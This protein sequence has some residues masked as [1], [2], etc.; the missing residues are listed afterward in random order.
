MDRLSAA[1]AGGQRHAEYRTT[2]MQTDCPL[3]QGTV[4]NEMDFQDFVDLMFIP[5]KWNPYYAA[6]VKKRRQKLLQL[7]LSARTSMIKRQRPRVAAAPP[8]PV[9]A[10]AQAAPA[11]APPGQVQ[12]ALQ[13]AAGVAANLAAQMAAGVPLP[14]D[15]PQPM[16]GAGFGANQ[17]AAHAQVAQQLANVL[18]QLAELQQAQAE[19]AAPAPAPVHAPAAAADPEMA[20]DGAEFELDAETLAMMEALADEELPTADDKFEMLLKYVHPDVQLKDTIVD[21]VMLNAHNMSGQEKFDYFVA[22]MTKATSSVAL[23]KAMWLGMQRNGLDEPPSAFCARFSKTAAASGKTCLDV[24]NKFMELLLSPWHGDSGLEKFV[25]AMYIEHK[26]TVQD[27]E[28]L[29]LEEMADSAEVFERMVFSQAVA[30]MES[31][32]KRR[33]PGSAPRAREPKT[34]AP[35]TPPGSGS[36]K[37]DKAALLDLPFKE[38]DGK[39]YRAC[40][41]CY[42]NDDATVWHPKRQCP[43]FKGGGGRGGSGRGGQAM[44]GKTGAHGLPP[45][46]CFK[47]GKKGHY[48]SD[49]QLEH[50][51]DAGRT[52]QRQFQ[53]E[54]RKR[55]Q[56]G[57]EGNSSGKH[58]T[59]AEESDAE[60]S[61]SAMMASLA[62]L[63]GDI[64]QLKTAL[65]ASGAAAEPAAAPAG[66]QRAAG[67]NF[68]AHAAMHDAWLPASAVE[69]GF[70]FSDMY[71]SDDSGVGLLTSN[72]IPTAKC[73]PLG[74]FPASLMAADQLRRRG[75]PPK[76]QQ[77]ADAA[78][79]PTAPASARRQAS[80]HN[81][82][83]DEMRALR[84]RLPRGMVNPRDLATE[85]PPAVDSDVGGGVSNAQSLRIREAQ[86][87]SMLRNCLS[88]LKLGHVAAEL[89]ADASP[90]NLDAWHQ[91]KCSA[92]AGDLHDGQDPRSI[93]Y[94]QAVQRAVNVWAAQ[95]Q[96]N[97]RDFLKIDLQGLFREALK[98][99]YGEQLTAQVAPEQPV[100]PPSPGLD[101]PERAMLMAPAPQQ[102][103]QAMRAEDPVALQ[104]HRQLRHKWR[105]S[106]RWSGRRAV[107]M[108]DGSVHNILFN[109][110]PVG[111]I[112]LDAGANEPMINKRLVQAQHLAVNPN[113]RRITGI[114]GVPH[115]MPRTLDALT[116]TVFPEDSDK[117][118]TAM[119]SMIVMEGDSLPDLLLDNEMMAQIGIV[120]DTVNWTATYPTKPYQQDSELVSLPLFRPTD[121]QLSALAQM[122][123]WDPPAEE[124]L[125]PLSSPSVQSPASFQGFCCMAV[126]QGTPKM[127][128]EQS[129]G[130]PEIEHLPNFPHT[131]SQVGGGEDLSFPEATAS[132]AFHSQVK[133]S[134]AQ[135]F[136]EGMPH[137]ELYAELC[138]SVYTAEGP[139]EEAGNAYA[140]VVEQFTQQQLD[141]IPALAHTA[142]DKLFVLDLEAVQGH[143]YG[144]VSTLYLC[145]GFLTSLVVDVTEGMHMKK[146]RILERNSLRRVCGERVLQELHAHY[147]E[148]LPASAIKDAFDWAEAIS[149]D[150][151]NL[152]GP[153]L[154]H[155]FG[156]DCELVVHI[157]AGC[158]GHSAIGPKTGF[159]HAESGSLVVIAD[160]LSD[161]QQILAKCRGIKRWDEA[162]SMFGYI[163]ENVPG[164]YRREQH[165]EMSLMA[166]RFMDRVFG[167]PNM[168]EPALCGDLATR[169]AK[170]WS[171]MFTQEFYEA[172]EPLFHRTPEVSLEQV[173]LEL[174]DGRLQPQIVSRGKQLQGGLNSFGDRAQV[175]PKFVSEPLT[176]NQRMAEDG[177][178]GA[179]ML[180]VVGSNPPRFVPC[181]VSVRVRAHSFW[182]PQIECVSKIVD[183]LGLI[184][185]IGN[186]CAPTSCR[187]MF[188]LAVG[189]S[190][191]VRQQAELMHHVPAET[192]PAR[193]KQVEDSR[194][195]F[196]RALDRVAADNI[197]AVEALDRAY[198][199]ARQ[200]AK[201]DAAKR[202][203]IEPPRVVTLSLRK[204][205]QAKARSDAKLLKAKA[206]QAKEARRK[207]AAALQSAAAASNQRTKEK[208]MGSKSRRQN[209]L[210]AVLLLLMA[211]ALWGPAAYRASRIAGS[212][213]ALAAE[214]GFYVPG[215]M[216]LEGHLPPEWPLESGPLTGSE[217][218]WMDFAAKH[219]AAMDNRYREAAEPGECLY[220]LA[221][222]RAVGTADNVTLVPSTLVS[223]KDGSQHQWQI[224]AGFQRKSEFAAMMD[225][226]PEWY[227]WGLKDL[228]T[229][230]GAEY[231]ITLTDNRPIFSKQYHLAHREAE[232]AENWV[233]ELEEAGL[234]KEIESPYAAPVVVAPKKDEAGQW[235]DLRYAIDYRRL[236]QVTVRDQYPTPVPEE[237]LARMNG[238]ALF[239]SMDA[240]KAFHQV[241]VAED[242]QPML[243]FHSGHRLLTWRRMP[244]GGKNSVACW[245]RIVDDA[246]QGL[247]FAQAFADDVVVWSDGDEVEHMRRVR[248][249]LERLHSK[250]IQISPKKTK[251]GMQRLEFLGHV[252][253]ASGVEP[254]WDKVEAIQ[255][256]PV[257]TSASEVRSFIGM[258]TYYCKFL[259]HYS[260]VKRP[261]TDL[262]KKG[263]PWVWGEAQEEAFKQ[264]KEMLVSAPVLRNP[265][266]TRPFILHTDWSKAGVG[267]CLS[268]I[269]EDGQEYAVAFASRMNSRAEAAFSSYEGEVSAVVY[270]VQR[271]RYYLWG[272]KFTLVTDCKAMEWLTT[273]AKLRSKL[274]RW[275]LILAEYD[276]DIVHRPGKDNT[277]PDL[278]S[279]QPSA[280]S[281]GRPVGIAFHFARRPAL[282]SSA[283]AFMAQQWGA[284]VAAGWIAGQVLEATFSRFDPW[285]DE[286][287]LQF[288]RGELPREVVSALRWAALRRQCS[289]YMAREG[290]IWYRTATGQ[291]LEV[292]PPAQRQAVV[293]RIHEE[294]GHL[295]RDRTHAMAAHRYTWPAMW[296]TVADTIKSCSQCDRVR[297]SFDRQVDV[298]RPLPLMGLFYRFH[299][300]AA[301]NLPAAKNGAKHVL[302]IVE[303]FSKW[304]DLVPLQELTAQ[305][306]AAAFKERV[307]ARFGRPVE[308]TTDHGSEY[309]AE[310]HQLCLELGIDHRLITP[311]HPEANGMAE[312]I[313]GVLKKGLRKFVL[314][315]GVAAWPEHLPTIEFGY[316]T[317]PQ[318]TT[319]FSPYFLVY[320]R[321][322]TFPE[323]VR[324]LLDGGS[325]D[326]E[327]EDVM[328]RLITE[329]ATALRD[330]MPLAYERAVAAQQRQAVRYQRVRQRDLP[331]RQHRFNVG[332][333]VYVSQRPINTLDVRTSRTI[334]RVRAIRPHG[335]LELEGADGVTVRVRMEMCAPCMI[336]NL[337]TGDMGVAADLACA[338]CGSPSMADP[339]LLCDR[340]DLGYHLGCLTPPLER[341]PSGTW[342]CP[343][344]QPMLQVSGP[345]TQRLAPEQ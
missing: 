259:D 333:Y 145:A 202:G 96:L 58:V 339:M 47:C 84:N 147:P 33:T 88:H 192:A 113:G 278:L 305:A 136:P 31:D 35:I 221:N 340:C 276:M 324:A 300:D 129:D 318:Q 38:V 177:T 126:G 2:T 135:K 134:I 69:D 239:T 168:H 266:W 37:S 212:G 201:T 172:H 179:G 54:K 309:K 90:E 5:R 241:P 11:A 205:R 166:S 233:K 217:Y 46:T 121:Q 72:S 45:P 225:S 325:L 139:D 337:V 291:L 50:Q 285:A 286:E 108:L 223:A 112:V 97:I 158:Q 253:S 226:D 164:P 156:S 255:K 317:T 62:Q 292:P 180:E 294:N 94:H 56:R 213:A 120:I 209:A 242:T 151:Y 204:A 198:A 154:L 344:C 17:A 161:L 267:A 140:S 232:F 8:P 195:V 131:R 193:D 91:A 167:K 21:T 196:Q 257:P 83:H 314:T 297:A 75:R 203:L 299:L 116:V 319:G 152:D 9:D 246:L 279:R 178:P 191:F 87:E 157:E 73:V 270:A 39:H 183:E 79:R 184:R 275:S 229:V 104:L 27:N 245:Q 92:L 199:D 55:L 237:I 125:P 93:A 171:N 169:R 289:R 284:P 272:Q 219:A 216:T 256:L 326:V 20:D 16:G 211:A 249:V 32:S 51:N 89:V 188:R 312:R 334:L 181:P 307:L 102:Q 78:A 110:K 220:E 182:A 65:T 315:H 24:N 150:A 71:S 128:S 327:D 281:N 336:P 273:T 321:E 28:V 138:A 230:T 215:G 137:R 290:R 103:A 342:C 26:H 18:R 274:A 174:T 310:F 101:N 99:V 42:V 61:S 280:S 175:L 243:A 301:V 206:I 15:E 185:L 295:G 70:A 23:K 146:V 53:E 218:D 149:H 173:V 329:R 265:D 30:R 148:R 288:I 251:L 263:A 44:L 262:T 59:F 107:A 228:R 222:P 236:N 10:P 293:M 1:S 298:M 80:M 345:R 311:G 41:K 254:Q 66:R 283:M 36:G 106:I 322:P 29:H 34:P 341:V 117:E 22:E 210:S 63:V 207:A 165:T 258:A 43:Y 316:R 163:M 308:V 19:P 282:Q 98:K 296:Q 142:K 7:K 74:L 111:Q 186:V 189:Y 214:A 143:R 4:E 332:D 260:H 277:V 170:W 114:T 252:V 194:A 159:N 304:V 234:V 25:S 86:L 81:E 248:V 269:A 130:S 77:S 176:V 247:E 268:Q 240:Q 57:G 82:D 313:V 231:S 235:T 144:G 302:I 197:S 250:N 49:C 303:A 227:A 105:Q 67:N 306:V 244:F 323:Q 328:Y 100:V 6:C 76:A 330:A 264:I 133:A 187:V 123:G 115:M 200:A 343:R 287:A 338:V 335:V 119:D 14:G 132:A 68:M 320:G 48:A 208:P 85:T 155:E 3:Y 153:M 162:P 118:A 224:G 60:T 190:A 141:A 261:L 331:P 122:K 40:V 271:F 52:A 109:G 13:N 160:A 64:Q 12:D 238:A 124:H 127:G 95:A